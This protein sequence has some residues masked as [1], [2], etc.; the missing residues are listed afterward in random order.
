MSE[1]GCARTFSSKQRYTSCPLKRL[2][3]DKVT[4]ARRLIRL[5]DAW[6]GMPLLALLMPVARA[7]RVPHPRQCSFSTYHE[8][9]AKSPITRGRMTRR[10][11]EGICP[12]GT[13][14]A[15]ATL[16]QKEIGCA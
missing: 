6:S 12:L 13:L 5:P 15:D 11:P 14:I 3:L 8:P 16:A 9:S 7:T 4:V 10:F 1:A 2:G